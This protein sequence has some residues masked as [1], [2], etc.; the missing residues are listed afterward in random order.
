MFELGAVDLVEITAIMALA[1]VIQMAVGVGLALCMVPLLTLVEPSLTPA[2]SALAAFVV[3]AAMVRGRTGLIVPR[4]MGFGAA[5]L[6]VGTLIGVLLLFLIP[7]KALPQVFGALILV[8]VALSVV[9]LRLRPIPRDILGASL[10]SGVMGGMSGVHGP[11][12][13]LVYAGQDPDRV[14]ATLG[15]YWMVAYGLLIAMHLAAGRVTL[16]TLGSAVALLPGIALG[17]AL[18]PLIVRHVN[19]ERMRIGLLAIAA[20]SGLVL[21]L[22]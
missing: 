20:A 12:I 14:R 13:G 17:V 1:T 7:T 3:M 22:R 4:E 5:G 15:L 18:A 2:P 9:G 11:L 16:A 6:F 19:R 21:I 8:A 10:L